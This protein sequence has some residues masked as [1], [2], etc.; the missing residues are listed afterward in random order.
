MFNET[1]ANETARP[2]DDH[3]FTNVTETQF[4]EAPLNDPEINTLNT[5]CA[6]IH[7]NGSGLGICGCGSGDEFPHPVGAAH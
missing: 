4:L 3:A 7:K 6:N 5:L 2:G 1:T